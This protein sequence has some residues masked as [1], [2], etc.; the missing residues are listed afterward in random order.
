M[1]NLAWNRLALFSVYILGTWQQAQGQVK[2]PKKRT[3]KTRRVNDAHKNAKKIKAIDMIS[4]AK[5]DTNTKLGEMGIGKGKGKGK[6][7]GKIL[8][9]KSKRNRKLM[10]L[11]NADKQLNNLKQPKWK[12]C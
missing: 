2:N 11:G 12:I 10:F 1:K 4:R 7:K 5:K 9:N 6:D 3:I 8:D